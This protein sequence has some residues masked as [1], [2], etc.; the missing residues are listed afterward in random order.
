MGLDW[1]NILDGAGA[2]IKKLAYLYVYAMY[3][4]IKNNTY[5]QKYRH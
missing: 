3:F 1:K 2:G 5:R 4:I